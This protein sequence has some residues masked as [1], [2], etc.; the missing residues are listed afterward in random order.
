[1]KNC[2]LQEQQQQEYLKNGKKIVS[3]SR[4]K[5]SLKKCTTPEF[6]N[7]QQSSEKTILF[8]YWTENSFSLAGMKNSL[9]K[10]FPWEKLFSL[11]GISDKWKKTAFHQ[12][13]KQF[14]L[15][16]MKFFCKN[17]LPHNFNN[18]YQQQKEYYN[19]KKYYF[20]QTEKDFTA[21]ASA[22]G[23]CF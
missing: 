5:V 6:Q 14:L 1:M 12:R 21:F 19:I 23:N 8:L 10:C 13:E 18:G 11:P 4:N 3:T 22:I 20:N 9:K 17:C 7:L 15:G 16:T 2:S